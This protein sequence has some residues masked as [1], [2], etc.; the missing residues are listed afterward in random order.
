VI[1]LNLIRYPILWQHFKY[2]W[3]LHLEAAKKAVVVRN[4]G[5][6]EKVKR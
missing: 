4:E 3:Y 6:G 1:L 5:G 2:A